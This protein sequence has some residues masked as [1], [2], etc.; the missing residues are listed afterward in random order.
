[1]RFRF[2]EN[3]EKITFGMIIVGT[4]IAAI[5]FTVLI[6]YLLNT[7]SYHEGVNKEQI[8]GELENDDSEFEEVSMK[9]GKNVQEATNE[10]NSVKV[11]NAVSENSVNTNLSKEDNTN[12]KN[13]ENASIS[14]ENSTNSKKT[15]NANISK[16]NSTISTAGKTSSAN[17]KTNN[18]T[19]EKKETKQEIKFIAPIKGEIVRE[20]APDSLVYSKTLDEWITHNGIDIKADKTSVVVAASDG[21]VTS[22]KNDPRYGI[23]VIVSHNNGYKTLYA[24]LLTAEYVVENEEIKEGQTIG[25]I[26]NSASFEIA[27]DYHLHFEMLKDED[28]VNPKNYIDF[29]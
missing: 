18:N 16:E 28:Y 15:E 8:V 21:I 7:A 14:K 20:F 19:E 3:E 24:N 2:K 25:T 22:I 29:N 26:G 10:L 4:I 13:T 11:D 23:T 5:L 9:M 17:K 6:V 12:S 27:D 1:M